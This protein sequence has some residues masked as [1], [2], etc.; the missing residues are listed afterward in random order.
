MELG[1]SLGVQNFGIFSAYKPFQNLDILGG[2]DLM[3]YNN[4]DYNI[5]ARLYPLKKFNQETF[6]K[7]TMYLGIG[8]KSTFK[9]KYTYEDK[10]RKESVFNIPQIN[11][12]LGELGFRYNFKYNSE[13]EHINTH[14]KYFHL[15]LSLGITYLHKL[16]SN[17]PSI[18]AGLDNDNKLDKINKFL[19]G[20]FGFQLTFHVLINK[21]KN[22]NR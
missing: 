11:Y 17:V 13:E 8:Y 1:V 4:L 20:G 9:S 21:K 15:D 22:I 3:R 6:Y 14:G 10:L 2:I 19:E 18:K 12:L 5:R 7:G 16:N